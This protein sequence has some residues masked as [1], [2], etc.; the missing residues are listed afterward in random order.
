MIWC[1]ILS[2]QS[3]S[4]VIVANASIV[5]G[6]GHVR[7]CRVLADALISEGWNVT[8][9]VPEEALSV[10]PMLSRYTTVRTAF[11]RSDLAEQLFDVLP[12]GCDLLVVDHYDLDATFEA[13]CHHWAKRVLVIDDLANRTHDCNWLVDQTPGRMPADYVPLLPPACCLM[14]GPEYALLDARFRACRNTRYERNHVRR[15]LVSFG[16]TDPGGMTALALQG[17]EQSGLEVEID[18]VLGASSPN[19][20]DVRC[21]VAGLDRPAN[22][23]VDVD[24]MA[25]LVAEADLAVGAGG[26]SALE[27]CCL[28]VPSVILVVAEN[29][30]GNVEGLVRAGAAISFGANSPV[31]PQTL[32]K[33]LRELALDFIRRR[34]MSDA[35]REIC[36][37]LGP[38]RV[39][40]ALN[41]AITPDQHV[42]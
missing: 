10:Y 25:S 31:S 6:G 35:G 41:R 19:L 20:E 13:A 22:L 7:R 11:Q 39:M 27:R 34:S 36:D 14:L 23:H 21:I 42:D 2:K 40:N 8:F 28:G 33:T 16:S 3:R 37:A 5:V 30:R 1:A 12:G 4:A 38:K 17:L 29:Q 15:V 9:A 32:G 18:I 24:D 26:V